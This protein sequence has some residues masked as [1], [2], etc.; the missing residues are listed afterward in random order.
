MDKKDFLLYAFNMKNPKKF[1]IALGGSIVFQ[2]EIDLDFLK[3]FYAFIKSRILKYNNKFII[4]IGGGAITRKYQQA[5]SKIS[6]VSNEDKDWLGIH[7]TR[8][9]AHLIRTIF[10]K[11]ANPVIFEQRFKIKNFGKYSLI[12]GA[13]WKPGWSTDFVACQIA[14]DFK[15]SKV[16]ILGHP[17][18]VYTKDPRKHKNAKPIKKITWQ[19]Y[20]KLIPKKWSP[21]L[22]APV[23]PIAARLSQKENLEA[24]VAN[25]LDLRNLQRILNSQIFKGTVLGNN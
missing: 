1:V 15:I 8:L 5:A 21:G 12:I 16:I 18:Y 4:V 13:G 6:K 2:E 19:N 10:K 7:A 20:L 11:Q 3:K 24:V 14:V 17:D 22:H 25:A 9:N 23:D